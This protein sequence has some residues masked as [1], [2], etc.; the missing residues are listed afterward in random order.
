MTK[1]DSSQSQQPANVGSPNHRKSTHRLPRLFW[2]LILPAVALLLVLVNAPSWA[3]PESRPL[4][5]TVPQPTPTATNTPV[6]TATPTPRGD[7]DDDEETGEPGPA[8]PGDPTVGDLAGEVV[9]PQ[10]NVRAG[11]GTGFAIIGAFNSGAQVDILGRSEDGEWWVVCCVP[12]SGANGWVSSQFVA[13]AD[14]AAPVDTLPVV[15]DLNEPLPTPEAPA[16]TESDAAPEEP[17][18]F[19]LA[20][21]MSAFPEFAWQG[22]AVVLDFVVS[23]PGDVPA[24][25]VELRNELSL[26]LE[27]VSSEAEGDGEIELSQTDAGGTVVTVRW[28]V[29]APGAT[30]SAGITVVISEELVDGQVIDNL[31]VAGARNAGTAS[32]GISLGMP[33]TLLPTFR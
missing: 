31:A 23:N 18:A 20:L 24:D 17:P 25:A 21:S 10:L 7:D 33:P 5:Q 28:P 30:A 12:G 13:L 15:A 4:G 26:A 22:Q 32:A 27:Y 1:L 6:A 2:M 3:A 8:E 19:D 16:E 9:A 14:G 29:L 11:P